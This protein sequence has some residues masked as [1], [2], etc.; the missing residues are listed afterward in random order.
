MF[1]TLGCRERNF[2][3]TPSPDSS[4]GLR[5]PEFPP[6]THDHSQEMDNA[7][8]F[9]RT[10][11]HSQTDS[12]YSSNHPAISSL[13][14]ELSRNSEIIHPNF[15][16]PYLHH[17]PELPQRASQIFHFL[18]EKR[19][20]KESRVSPQDTAS[21]SSSKE[22]I[23]L[24]S[25]SLSAVES[26]IPRLRHEAP[27]FDVPTTKIPRAKGQRRS[28]DSRISLAEP[29]FEVDDNPFKPSSSRVHRRMSSYS[30][31]NLGFV[32]SPKKYGDENRPTRSP[33]VRRKPVPYWDEDCSTCECYSYLDVGSR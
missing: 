24:L 7:R 23:L 28:L 14:V 3:S 20:P 31:A 22:S 17:D 16:S 2:S 15:A 12:M 33:S 9:K 18:T 27:E 8:S 13:D 21:S 1:L 6:Y 10:T 19:K 4:I 26:K 30:D 25:K 11:F 32:A 5:T 29:A